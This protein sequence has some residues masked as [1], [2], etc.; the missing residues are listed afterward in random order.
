MTRFTPLVISCTLL[1]TSASACAD[2]DGAV[3]NSSR[4]ASQLD[5]TARQSPDG[6]THRLIDNSMIAVADAKPRTF[7]RHDLVQII[8]QETSRAESTSELE[9]AK[10]YDISGS[11][12]AFPDISLSDLLQLQIYAGRTTNLPALGV[13]FDKEFAGEGDYKR[14]DT[15]TTRLTAEVIAIRPNGNLV[16]E[17]RTYIRT[18]DEETTIM[19]TGECRQEDVTTAN[20]VISHRIHDLRVEKMN[21]G[22]LRKASEKGLIASFLDAIFA[23]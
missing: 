10:E 7:R 19:V 16:L 18:D 12:S 8:V 2:D 17:A 21:K 22:E 15:I 6:S 5:H 3:P 20:T 4:L 23:F 1:L 13:E 14:E 11:V 9:T